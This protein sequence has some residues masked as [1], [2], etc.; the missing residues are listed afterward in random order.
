MR[1]SSYQKGDVIIAEGE[2][3]SDAY[4]INLGFVEVYRTGP[5][6]Q[7]LSILGPGDIFGEMALI[8]ERSRSASV[9]ARAISAE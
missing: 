5:P 6:E 4:I 7:R 1:T 3:T 2:F 9:R 8:S